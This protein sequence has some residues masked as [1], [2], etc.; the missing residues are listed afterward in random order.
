MRLRL[1]VLLTAQEILKKI[2]KSIHK[3]IELCLKN[4]FFLLI[5][6]NI[7]SRLRNIQAEEKSVFLI[8][9]LINKKTC[10]Q[11]PDSSFIAC[12]SLHT[13]HIFFYYKKLVK[14]PIVLNVS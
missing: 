12:H 6:K 5:L 11:N 14:G 1:Q 10:S 13:V 3:L 7:T 8:N 9:I 2:K 4:I